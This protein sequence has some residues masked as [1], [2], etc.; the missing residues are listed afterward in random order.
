MERMDRVRRLAGTVWAVGGLLAMLIWSLTGPRDRAG[1]IT[2]IVT[3]FVI[4]AVA[5]RASSARIAWW[6]GARLAAAAIGVLLLG[7]VGDRFGLLGAP[8]DPG[9]S[10]GDWAHFRVE[11]AELVPWSNLVQ[12]AAVAATIAELALGGCWSPDS[13]GVGPGR[14][15]PAC[16]SSTWSRWCQAWAQDRFSNTACPCSSA[17]ACSPRPAGLTLDVAADDATTVPAPSAHN[18][19]REAATVGPPP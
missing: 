7:A 10:W 11:T 2:W 13:G 18:G 3:A 5:A 15:A 12:P 4:A 16:S 1:V 17:A 6:W 8:G 9:V 19:L 14:P